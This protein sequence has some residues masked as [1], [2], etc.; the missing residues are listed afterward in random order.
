VFTVFNKYASDGAQSVIGYPE[1]DELIQQ[2]TVAI[3][4]ERQ[5]LWQEIFRRI[6]EDL[7]TDVMM[8]HM[9]GFTRVSPRINFTPTISTNSE[10]Q[11]STVTFNE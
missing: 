8:H 11:I 5:E 3:N 10:I 9:V 7:V 6:H 4:P 1:L 2:A